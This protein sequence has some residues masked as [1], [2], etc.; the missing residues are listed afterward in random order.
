LAHGP[1]KSNAIGAV[2]AI[3]DNLRL[4]DDL[5]TQCSAKL[6]GE[7]RMNSRIGALALRFSLATAGGR[8]ERSDA[9]N[10]CKESMQGTGAAT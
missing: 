6:L 8:T 3:R 9:G 5:Q 4:G 2:H 7:G 10:G 1:A